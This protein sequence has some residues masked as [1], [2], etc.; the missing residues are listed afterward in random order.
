MHG[1]FLRTLVQ[2]AAPC[3]FARTASVLAAST[4]RRLVRCLYE[5]PSATIVSPTQRPWDSCLVSVGP[6]GGHVIRVSNAPLPWTVDPV[7]DRMRFRN[8]AATDANEAV[9]RRMLIPSTTTNRTG[10]QDE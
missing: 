5:A 2:K 7:H 6:K 4:C 8:T 9:R 1:A 10:D 3:V